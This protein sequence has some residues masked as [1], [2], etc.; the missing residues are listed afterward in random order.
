M[1]A[2]SNS[3]KIF[4]SILLIVYVMYKIVQ[5]MKKEFFILDYDRKARQNKYDETNVLTLYYDNHIHN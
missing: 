5:N 2:E 4:D 3:W 1:N